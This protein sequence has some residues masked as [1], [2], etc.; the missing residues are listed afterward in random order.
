MLLRLDHPLWQAAHRPLFL[1]AGLCALLAPAVW[2]WPGG[3][4]VDPVR[5]H[6]HELVFGM[7]GAAVGGYLLT[8]LPNWTGAGRVAPQSVRALTLLWVLARLTLPFGVGLPKGLLLLLS[9]GYFAALGLILARHLIAARVWRR[10]WLVGV[11]AGMALGDAAFLSDTAW[12][13][14]PSGIPLAMVVLFATLISVIGGRAVPA[15][16]RSWMQ[17]SA[18]FLRLRDWPGLSAL[19]LASTVLGGG[20]AQSGPAT[21]AG[22]L[23]VL[24]GLLQGIRLAGWQTLHARHYPALLM[25]HLAWAWVPIG[26]FLLGAAMLRPDVMPQSA[27]LHAFT[28]GAMGSMIVAISG[29]AAMRRQDGKLIAGRGLGVAFALVWLAALVRVTEPFVPQHWPDPVI[30][31]AAMWMTGW[32]VFLWAYRPALQGPVPSPILSARRRELSEPPVRVRRV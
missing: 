1:C 14:E 32:G 30:A 4:G 29:R 28:M 5:W 7:G 13:P 24:A 6:L 9:E 3:L 16:T 10:L 11:I 18:P 12:L 8:A 15:F 2:L 21:G 31:S 22:I 26:L 19:A 25:L 27:A 20:L 17:H 23:L